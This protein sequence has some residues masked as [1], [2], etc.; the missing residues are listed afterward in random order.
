MA[1][2]DAE[3][4]R[5]PKLPKKRVLKIPPEKK[6]KPIERGRASRGNN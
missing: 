1:V 6:K 2:A 5:R 3:R 4:P